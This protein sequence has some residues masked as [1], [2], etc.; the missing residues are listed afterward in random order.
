MISTP[1]QAT[2]AAAPTPEERTREISDRVAAACEGVRISSI[3]TITGVHPETVRRYVT[4]KSPPSGAFLAALCD[5]LGISPRWLLLGDGPRF[6]AEPGFTAPEY[7][8]HKETLLA[9]VA[10]LAARIEQL[11]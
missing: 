1:Q 3:A 11:P 10:Q 9:C 2:I 6:I 8:S 5:G 4:G 7:G